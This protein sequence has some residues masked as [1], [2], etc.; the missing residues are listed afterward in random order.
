[1]T[2]KN[3]ESNSSQNSKTDHDPREISKTELTELLM[4]QTS[5]IMLG[6]AF[7]PMTVQEANEYLKKAKRGRWLYFWSA[8][9]IKHLN[10]EVEY[11][12]EFI[13]VFENMGNWYTYTYQCYMEDMD[14]ISNRYS[15]LSEEDFDLVLAE[16]DANILFHYTKMIEMFQLMHNRTRE[17]NET[18]LLKV[19]EETNEKTR[20]NISDVVK[21]IKSYFSKYGMKDSNVK[22]AITDD[23]Q[24]NSVMQLKDE[25][26]KY[27]WKG[28]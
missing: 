23:D 1:M 14:K 27:C 20:I 22:K 10:E 24:I 9:K 26:E 2:K 4:M 6:V 18:Y 15:L 12:T 11:W 7:F 3:T 19:D 28:V 5:A 16:N 17:G 25:I 21:T 13:K 8:S